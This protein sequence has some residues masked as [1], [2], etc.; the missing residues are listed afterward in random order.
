MAS[1]IIHPSDIVIPDFESSIKPV[2]GNIT[3]VPNI[4]KPWKKSVHAT[5]INPPN[6]V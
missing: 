2:I 6:N 5:A 3:S 4:K 1:A